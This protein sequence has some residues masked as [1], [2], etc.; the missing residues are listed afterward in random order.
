MPRL[1]KSQIQFMKQR[2]I[3][4]VDEIK[5]FNDIGGVKIFEGSEGYG[6]KRKTYNYT[7]GWNSDDIIKRFTTK[8]GISN[9][10]RI[11]NLENFKNAL[12]LK[13]QKKT[14]LM[15]DLKRMMINTFSNP[16][17]AKKENEK[18]KKEAKEEYITD[19]EYQSIFP[20]SD[21]CNSSRI[22][23]VIKER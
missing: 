22:Y 13:N 5:A 9:A 8:K 6:K 7:R 17:E 23:K 20:Y 4:L 1:S 10:D 21:N 19:E 14:Q 2:I 16:E 11:T 18:I 3:N 12:I 15:S